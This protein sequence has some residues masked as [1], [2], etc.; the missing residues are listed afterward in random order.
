MGAGLIVGICVAAVVAYLIFE[1]GGGLGLPKGR[2]PVILLVALAVGAPLIAGAVVGGTAYAI[3]F[4]ALKPIE[5]SA[6]AR[7]HRNHDDKVAKFKCQRRR[8]IASAGRSK[9]PSRHRARRP[10]ISG[11]FLLSHFNPE[12]WRLG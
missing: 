7:R 3:I 2:Y 8:E 6:T 5:A 9:N 4:A 1:D 10:P 11:A 12:M